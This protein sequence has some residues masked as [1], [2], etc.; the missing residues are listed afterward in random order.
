M[1]PV[2]DSSSFI[3]APMLPTEHLYFSLFVLVAIWYYLQF[4]VIVVGLGAYYHPLWGQPQGECP[5]SNCLPCVSSYSL[6]PPHLTTTTTHSDNQQKS[7]ITDSSSY[8]QMT[9]V[10]TTYFQSFKT[11][12]LY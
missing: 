5:N 10:S 1:C 11:M 9:Y 6:P 8:S 7:I 3:H 4:H 2:L 12:Y